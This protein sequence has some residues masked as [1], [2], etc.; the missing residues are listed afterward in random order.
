MTNLLFAFA[1]INAENTKR[2]FYII[3]LILII[4]LVVLSVIGYGIIRLTNHQGKMLDRA[5]HDPIKKCRIIKDQKHFMRYAI[6]KNKLLFFHQAMIPVLIMLGGTVILL[7]YCA[8]GD[9]WGYNPWSMND[10][11]GSLLITWD[12][13]TIITINPGDAKGILINWPKIS[14]VPHFDIHNW[15]GYIVGICYLVGGL[16]Y[17]YTV[18]GLIG[19]TLRIL[20]L[21]K[22]IFEK[23]LEGFN[24]EDEPLDSQPK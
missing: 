17:L 8:I 24:L 2:I 20:H 3:F 19:R 16:W 7:L 15:C 1:Q 10:G 11:F 23:S 4:A 22:T 6:K 18:N 13:S 9:K 5:I 14:H 12:F 21:R